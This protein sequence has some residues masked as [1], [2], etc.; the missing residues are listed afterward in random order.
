[1][2]VHHQGPPAPQR[3]H[4]AMGDERVVRGAP[5]GVDPVQAAQ[6]GGI[7]GEGRPAGAQR[8]A[9][10]VQRVA[11]GQQ[12]LS[13]GVVLIRVHVD[14]SV[15][16][17]LNAGQEHG[18][19]LQGIMDALG[20]SGPRQPEGG[21]GDAPRHGREGGGWDGGHGLL[22]M[23]MGSG[24]AQSHG[25][26]VSPCDPGWGIPPKFPKKYAG[27]CVHRDHRGGCPARPPE[28]AG[29]PCHRGPR[30][31]PWAP[32]SIRITAPRSATRV[33]PP[34]PI[35]GSGVPP[36][37]PWCTGP[38]GFRDEADPSWRPRWP[39]CP[40]RGPWVLP[41]EPGARRKARAWPIRPRPPRSGAGRSR[42]PGTVDVARV[43]LRDPDRRCVAHRSDRLDPPGGRR[44]APDR[45]RAPRAGGVAADPADRGAAAGAQRRPDRADRSGARHDLRRG[46]LWVGRAATLCPGPAFAPRSARG[47][48]E[49]CG[50]GPPP[51][52]GAPV[53]PGDR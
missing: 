5:V 8:V 9:L 44:G 52:S 6:R 51:A 32:R 36:T 48:V 15:E 50:S 1:M 19:G 17:V 42:P 12:N 27:R 53:R 3:V 2:H 45:G 41:H 49:R 34:R 39:R 28:T 47:P 26:P 37:R 20:L 43:P 22:R 46:G 30:R 13:E 16:F 11:Q 23:G 10:S 40:W 7:R 35:L 14:L 29:P 21:D 25:L 4:V 33:A 24:I 18:L 31:S 38:G